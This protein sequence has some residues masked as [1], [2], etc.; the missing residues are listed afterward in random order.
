MKHFRILRK[1]GNTWVI[2]LTPTDVKDRGLEERQTYEADISEIII[3]K[4]KNGNK[5]RSDRIRA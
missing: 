3:K 2:C 4:K 5:K 1:W